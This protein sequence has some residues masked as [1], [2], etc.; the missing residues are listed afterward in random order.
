MKVRAVGSGPSPVTSLRVVVDEIH[1]SAF[2]FDVERGLS[3][4]ALSVS[5]DLDA[6]SRGLCRLSQNG[7]ESW[8]LVDRCPDQ[9]NTWRLHGAAIDLW[10]DV[11]GPNWSVFRVTYPSSP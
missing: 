4:A 6:A 11:T 5:A 3:S 2:S 1:T 8:S 7:V 9:P 10:G